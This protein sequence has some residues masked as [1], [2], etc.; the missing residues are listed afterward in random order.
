MSSFTVSVKDKGRLLIPAALRAQAGLGNEVELIATPLPDGGFTVKTRKQILEALR[1][2]TTD[3]V[4]PEVLI[5]FLR[6]RDAA[7]TDRRH[8]LM[9][10]VFPDISPEQQAEQDAAILAKLGFSGSK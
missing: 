1:S 10:P 9:N 3:V 5:D 7:E 4:E 6:S 8:F 2:P